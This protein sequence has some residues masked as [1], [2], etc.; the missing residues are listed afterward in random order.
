MNLGSRD[1]MLLQLSFC[2][3]G[4]GPVR[5]AKLEAVMCMRLFMIQKVG[6]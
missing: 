2:L 5:A 6:I 4:L 1:C 3:T